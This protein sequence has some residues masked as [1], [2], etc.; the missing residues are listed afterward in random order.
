[1]AVIDSR[2]RFGS[3]VADYVRYRPGY[4][5]ELVSALFD[6][7]VDPAALR[8]ADIGSGTGIF[9]R[10]LLERGVAVTGV[11]PN[12]N[13]RTAAESWLRSF[14]K[15]TSLEGSAEETGLEDAGFDLVTAAQ[16]FHWFHNPRTRAEF[17]RIL[18][19][20]GRLALVWNRRRLDDPL[21]Q[22]Y[23][24]LLRELAPEYDKV[25]HLTLDDDE[26]GLFFETGKMTVSAFDNHQ[27]LDFEGLSGR[28]RSASYCPA[29]DSSEYRRLVAKLEQLFARHAVGG[30]VRFTYD[31]HLY[32]GPV[33][34]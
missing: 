5:A 29:E 21:Q 2:E 9:T 34:R 24:A 27:Q 3:R 12:A 4:P 14:E 30:V 32:L 16:A 1:V 28:L 19:P 23:D 15:F 11:E 13:M 25:N 33:A 17:A 6:D 26:I 8:A 10:L 18:K 31:S 7:G 22:S 20:E